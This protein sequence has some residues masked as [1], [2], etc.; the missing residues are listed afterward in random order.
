MH[1]ERNVILTHDEHQIQP[2]LLYF[3]ALKCLQITKGNYDTK[4]QYPG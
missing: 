4:I 2:P 1:F 3:L